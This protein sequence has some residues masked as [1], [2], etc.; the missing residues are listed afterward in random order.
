[1]NNKSGRLFSGKIDVGDF[2]AKFWGQPGRPGLLLPYFRA[3]GVVH[4][5]Y[6][7]SS[8]QLHPRE[9]W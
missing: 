5:D 4:L 8:S 2:G 3:Q 9:L 7:E 6:P 1:M